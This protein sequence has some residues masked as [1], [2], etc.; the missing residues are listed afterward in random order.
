MQGPGREQRGKG[1]ML[2]AAQ[3][4]GSVAELRPEKQW[5]GSCVAWSRRESCQAGLCK[6]GWVFF[7]VENNRRDT[8]CW[9]DVA[10]SVV[11]INE[12][13]SAGQLGLSQTSDE[14]IRACKIYTHSPWTNFLQFQWALF[15]FQY[16]EWFCRAIWATSVMIWPLQEQILW[17]ALNMCFCKKLPQAMLALLTAFGT[18]AEVYI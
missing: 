17:A 3:A 7:A 8:A 5:T 16:A 15:L 9:G 10:K 13:R 11:S 12:E 18:H 1:N 6:Q 4:C 2:E 14:S